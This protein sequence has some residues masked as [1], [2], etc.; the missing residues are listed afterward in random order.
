MWKFFSSIQRDNWQK[1]ARKYDNIAQRED[2]IF[3]YILRLLITYSKSFSRRRW[4]FRGLARR[5][6]L[7]F[8]LCYP[9]VLH[10][11]YLQCVVLGRTYKQKKN[12]NIQKPKPTVNS[13]KDLDAR[14]TVGKEGIMHQKLSWWLPVGRMSNS[15]FT[16]DFIFGSDTSSLSKTRLFG[17]L[18]SFLLVIKATIYLLAA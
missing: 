6:L 1:L 13:E 4:F 7:F 11:W 12:L 9:L 18:F 17:L 8:R 14:H 15:C 2:I 3:K 10:F 5:W 16:G